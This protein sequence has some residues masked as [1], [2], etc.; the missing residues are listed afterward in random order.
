VLVLTS[1]FVRKWFQL[2]PSLLFCAR[3]LWIMEISVR[4][5]YFWK[6]SIWFCFFQ[7]PLIECIEITFSL[8]APIVLLDCHFWVKKWIGIDFSFLLLHQYPSFLCRFDLTETEISLCYFLDYWQFSVCDI[9]GKFCTLLAELTLP[10][11]FFSLPYQA[12]S[13]GSECRLRH[14]E[15]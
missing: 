13:N 5:W 1:S 11:I 6:L 15:L 3:S 14:M 9:Q 8:K 10:T 4:K 12:D 2:Q 7:D